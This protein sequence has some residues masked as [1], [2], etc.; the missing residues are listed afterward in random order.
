MSKN[1]TINILFFLTSISILFSIACNN[2]PNATTYVQGK[3]LYQIHCANCHIETGEG[4]KGLI[5]PL[6]KADYLQNHRGELACIIRN[7]LK[8]DVVVNGIT[9]NQQV[10]LP[11][12]QLND[13]EITNVLNYV[14]TAWGNEQ[15]QVVTLDEVRAALAKCAQ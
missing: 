13:F 1:N 4:L 6:A 14:Q 15:K 10:M 7:G 11:N 3:A 2:D 5:P 12:T 9:Y 8:G